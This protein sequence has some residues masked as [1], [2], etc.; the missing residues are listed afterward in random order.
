ML[1]DW[2]DEQICFQAQAA[3]HSQAPNQLQ[4][5]V[6]SFPNTATLLQVLFDCKTTPWH[7]T[8]RDPVLSSICLT[9]TCVSCDPVTMPH[10]S[11][12]RSTHSVHARCPLVTPRTAIRSHARR[13]PGQRA[14]QQHQG[15]TTGPIVVVD[16]YDSFTFNL[17]QY[18]GDL[19]APFVVFK[20]D[21]KTV[22]ELRAL[23]PAG[24]LVSPGPGT[25]ISAVQ[26][27][28]LCTNQ[29]PAGRPEDSGISLAVVKELGPD[30]PVFGVC[31]GHQCIGQTFGGRVIRAPCGVMHG[32]T[33]DVFHTN[34]GL[35]EVAE[36]G[37]VVCKLAIILDSFQGLDNPFKAARYHSLV[38]EK[39]SCPEDLEVTAWTE[40]GTIMAVR[41]KQY[42]HVQVRGPVV[43]HRLCVHPVHVDDT[44][45]GRAVSSRKHHHEQWQAHR[46]QLCEI[47][48]VV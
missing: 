18:L 22:E 12:L 24:I 23:N 3:K 11:P 10:A 35:L 48:A 28:V 31:M 45:S 6:H 7:T 9:T 14:A 25:Q 47:L 41:H 32:K 44:H 5:N 19:G 27:N 34:T 42:P 40:D 16:N 20:N 21:E 30:F 1:M 46:C 38:I 37:Y 26:T 15:Q 29:S 17:C 39:E 13:Q 36:A 33:S 8:R 2:S 4:T 43:T